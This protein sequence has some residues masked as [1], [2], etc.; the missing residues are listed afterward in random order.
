[1]GGKKGRKIMTATMES[2]ECRNLVAGIFAL[3]A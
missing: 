1:M 3:W 2:D